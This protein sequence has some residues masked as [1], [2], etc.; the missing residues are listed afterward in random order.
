MPKKYIWIAESN[1]GTKYECDT[2]WEAKCAAGKHGRIVGKRL[3]QRRKPAPAYKPVASPKKRGRK[4]LRAGEEITLKQLG[5]L[6]W[7]EL[8][9]KQDA[10]PAS[11]QDL[12]DKLGVSRFAIYD[13]AKLPEW[14]YKILRLKGRYGGLVRAG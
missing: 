12:A 1:R 8:P 3:D 10:A 11:A 4:R 6:V 13:A 5:Q 7:K 14:R 2:E 9:R